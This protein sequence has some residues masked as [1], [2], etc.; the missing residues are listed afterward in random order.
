MDFAM[1][2][3]PEQ[4]SFRTQV[5]GWLAEHVPD[6]AL[7]EPKGDDA[8]RRQYLARRELGRLMGERGW[9][10]PSAPTEYGGGGLDPASVEVLGEEPRAVGL[11]NP[12]Y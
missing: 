12:P 1:S 7:G 10:Y 2:Y 4:Q 11:T 8:A 6:E 9:L 3:T 5:R